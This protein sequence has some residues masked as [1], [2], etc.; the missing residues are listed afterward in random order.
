MVR[1][2]IQ[3]GKSKINP[4]VKRGCAVN[5][6]IPSEA[7]YQWIYNE[8]RDL[9]R[10]TNGLIRRFIQKSTPLETISDSQIVELEQWLN[11]RPRKILNYR[12]PREVFQAFC[13][14]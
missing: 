4:A 5:I 9:I 3:L 6:T 14:T 8:R 7:T 12:T 13:C 1:D 2:E 10:Y 11:D